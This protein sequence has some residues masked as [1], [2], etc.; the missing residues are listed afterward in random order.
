MRW[1][2]L[3]FV[4]LALGLVI[5]RLILPG[6]LKDYANKVLAQSP[7]YDGQVESVSVHLWRGAYSIDGVK[8]VRTTRR[9][10]V[11]FFEAKRLDLQVDWKSLFQ[12]K[13]RGSTRIEEP[14]LNFVLGRS[15]EESQTGEDQPWLSMLNELAPFRLDKAEVVKGEIHLHTFYTTP[16]V[17]IFLSDI[18]ATVENLTNASD[19]L[20]PLIATVRA[21][22]K[23]MHTGDFELDMKLDPQAHRPN[24]ELATR[25]VDL[26]VRT[27][28]DLARA[29]GGLDFEDGRFDFVVEATTK[30]GFLDGYAKPLFR[31]AIVLGP[32][33][34]ERGNLL[35]VGWEAIVGAVGTIL[36]NHERQ[37]FGTRFAIVGE[38]DDPNAS[39]LEVIG[40][41]LRNAFVR[42][43][44]PNIEGRSAPAAAES[45][46]GSAQD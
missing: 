40:N 8:I 12:G 24:F 13:L 14:K 35:K 10:P 42:A 29:F 41:V 28:N 16:K 27:L 34:F 46:I 20:D 6:F 37:Q 25:L 11:P 23:A 21:E 45:A 26:D 44:L 32:S 17:N 15:R 5:L 9:M 43:Y 30:D 19:K 33:D 7:D 22:G 18:D 3:L 39:T 1:F 4:V 36:S 2:G 38:F 31:D